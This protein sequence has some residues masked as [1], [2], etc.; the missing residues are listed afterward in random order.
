MAWTATNPAVI[1]GATKK[2]DADVF[3]DNGVHLRDEAVAFAGVK[4]FAAAPILTP[5]TGILKGNGASAVT[6]AAA[7]TDFAGPTGLLGS[8]GANIIR[9]FWLRIEG[10]DASTT[11]FR[12]Y[13][14][15]SYGFNVSGIVN[16]TTSAVIGTGGN[17]SVGSSGTD[18]VTFTVSG[19]DTVLTVAMNNSVNGGNRWIRPLSAVITNSNLA[20]VYNVQAR[21]AGSANGAFQVVFGSVT[22]D[23]GVSLVTIG[24]GKYLYVL[25]TFVEGGV[26]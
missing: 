10:Y 21:S 20:T 25:V 17:A 19:S 26:E 24:A 3:F 6:V 12:A 23:A 13:H 9:S 11:K 5:L 15:S 18:Q 4:T 8:T 16:A 1:G 22:A 14:D 2:S 7:G